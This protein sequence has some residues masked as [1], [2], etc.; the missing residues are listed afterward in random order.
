MNLS[1]KPPAP[2]R[3]AGRSLLCTPQH[4]PHSPRTTVTT[5]PTLESL[6]L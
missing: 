3:N 5:V 4:L 1:Q 6:E 2:P